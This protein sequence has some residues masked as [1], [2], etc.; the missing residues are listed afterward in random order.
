VRRPA[1]A[2]LTGLL[3]AAGAAAGILALPRED[4]R[5]VD[6]ATPEARRAAAVAR[7][8][9]PGRVLQVATDADSG[10]WEVT[11]AQDGREY[12]V[13]LDGAN[14]GLLRLDYD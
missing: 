14:L 6:P 8:I 9:V 2:A 4:D 3:L 11:I 13:E 5:A 10:K 7:G 1:R 12:E